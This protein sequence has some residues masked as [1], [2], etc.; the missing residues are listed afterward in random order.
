MEQ[1]RNVGLMG[2]PGNTGV[3]DTLEYLLHFLEARGHKVIFDEDT[4]SVIARP[5]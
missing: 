2:R 1:F 4:A 5:G 3:V